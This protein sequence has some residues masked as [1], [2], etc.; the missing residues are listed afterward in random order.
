M[1]GSVARKVTPGAADVPTQPRPKLDQRK[2]NIHVTRRGWINLGILAAVIF[3]IVLLFI[4]LRSPFIS[5]VSLKD[6]SVQTVNPVPVEIVFGKKVDPAELVVTLDDEDC[7]DQTSLEEG[8]LW[9]DLNVPDGEH[10]LDIA[11]KGKVEKTVAFMVD[12]AP[13]VIMVDEMTPQDDG[14][15]LVKGR[16]EEAT[17]MTLEGNKLSFDKEGGFSFKVNPSDYPMVTLAAVDAAGNSC[18]IALNTIPP[19]KIKGTHISIW[20]AADSKLFAKQVDL[21]NRTELNGMQIDIKDESG[22]IGYD[23][24]VE[25]AN[26]ISSDLAKGGMDLGKVMDKL[27]YNDIYPIGRI[28]CFK[29]PVLT[30]K[31]PDL[32]VHDSRGGLWGDGKWVDPY[33]K[34]AWD[35]IVDIAT[36]AANNGFKEIQFDYMRFPTDGD[37]TTCVFPHQ[38][39]RVKDQVITDFV[40]YLRDQ[41]KPL[42]VQ[43][44]GDIFGLAASAQGSMGIGQ[45]VNSIGQYMDYL[46]PMVYP[47]HYNRGEYNISVPEADPY[48]T[49]LLSLEDFKRVLEGTNCRLRPW[50]QDFSLKVNYTPDMVQAQIQACYDAGVEEWL[51]WDPDCSFTEA[52]LVPEGQ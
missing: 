17:L 48:N 6:G 39:D 28:V 45:V 38:D 22:A 34:E 7:T 25:L 9:A 51:L 18:E 23:S 4:F 47:S 1:T 41:L 44:S 8:K 43:V 16:V 33:S 42:G 27:W 36:E 15:T 32:A 40:K 26:Q 31:R 50:L 37:I 11:Y 14:T 46:C 5:S 30:K 35:Y 12:T 13:P 52:A 10:R 29:D 49:V 21:I 2:M 19:P 3:L 20:I 24:Q